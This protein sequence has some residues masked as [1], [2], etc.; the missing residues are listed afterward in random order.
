MIPVSLDAYTVM[1]TDNKLYSQLKYDSYI[2]DMAALEPMNYYGKRKVP[3]L[4]VIDFMGKTPFIC[5][6]QDIPY[7]VLFSFD[8]YTNIP[9]TKTVPRTLYF[10]KFPVSFDEYLSSFNCVQ[11]H[12]KEGN[13]YLVNLTFPTP[14]TTNYSLYELFLY[15]N[16]PYKL[17]FNDAFV[18]FSPEAFVTIAQ[19]H[20]YTFPMK[21]TIDAHIPDAEIILR[22][23]QKEFAEHITVVDLLRNDLAR[24]SYNVTVEKFRYCST[25]KTHT[26][27]LIQTSSKIKGTLFNNYHQHLG[28]IFATLLPAGSVTGAPKKKTVEIIK[29]A[30]IYHRGY[31]TGVFGY[32]DGEN[33]FSAV[34]IRFIENNSSLTYKSGGGITVYSNPVD[35]YYELI[36]KVYVPIN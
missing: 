8:G 17:F 22:N 4:F 12:L 6:L 24:V 14:I 28:D 26:K 15:S 9:H 30:E 31:Y 35:E 25:V 32:F 1:Q 2:I 27:T 20:I 19:G 11:H 5:P 13:S 3:F 34:I 21:G 23:D 29:E 33:V 10:E 18:V 7:S 36:E 16:A